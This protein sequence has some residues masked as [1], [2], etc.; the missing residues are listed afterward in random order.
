MEPTETTPPEVK[1]ETKSYT[2]EEYEHVMS[3]LHKFKN[4]TKSLEEKIKALESEKLKATQD[5]KSIAELKEQEANEAQAKLTGLKT[6]ILE[7]KKFSYIKDAALKAGAD[8]RALDLIR[9]MSFP[10]VQM[11]H[12]VGED[13]KI[14]EVSVL[15]AEKAIERLKTQQPFLFNSM[16]APNVNSSSPTVEGGDKEITVAD[17]IAAEKKDKK[18]YAEMLTKYNKQKRKA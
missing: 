4:S 17:L 8:P 15:G 6:T 3:D 11:S 16:K 18:L 5:W 10:E 12:N 1:T 14:I 9:K 2:Q 7:D 13:G